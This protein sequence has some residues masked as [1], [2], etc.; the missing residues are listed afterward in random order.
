M[1]DAVDAVVAT[2][3]GS[4]GIYTDRDYF[5]G[6]FKPD[7]GERYIREVPHYDPRVIQC[8]KDVCTHIYETHGRFPAHVDAI[9]VPGVWLQVHH[10]DLEYY[11][12]LFQDGYT[13]T[14]KQHEQM[15]HGTGSSAAVGGDG[16]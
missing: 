3:Y 2:K 9:Y 10:L 7:G 12:K 4:Q 6:V 5:N 14:H 13:E 1:A 11:D 15:W 16:E 8:V